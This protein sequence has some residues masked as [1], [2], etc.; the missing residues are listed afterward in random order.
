MHTDIHTCIHAYMHTLHTLQ[1]VHTLKIGLV[2]FNIH[3]Q[4]Y[5]HTLQTA[6]TANNN[7]HTLHIYAWDGDTWIQA[8]TAYTTNSKQY[9]HENIHDKPDRYFHYNY[10][11][12][13]TDSIGFQNAGLRSDNSIISQAPPQ[14]FRRIKLDMTVQCGGPS[15]MTKSLHWVVAMEPKFIPNPRRSTHWHISNLILLFLWATKLV[16]ERHHRP[17]QESPKA[18]L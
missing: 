3:A 7:I 5:M 13:D 8:Y 10:Q 18:H 9:I 6:N 17:W 16:Q 1:T 2:H 14:P 12:S 15:A 4:A 11:W